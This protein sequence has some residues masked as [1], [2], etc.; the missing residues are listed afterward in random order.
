MNTDVPIMHLKKENMNNIDTSSTIPLCL[1]LSPHKA[2]LIPKFFTY[3][4]ICTLIKFT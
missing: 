4:Y 1:L 3:L 2:N